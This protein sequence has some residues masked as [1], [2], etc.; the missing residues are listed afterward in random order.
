MDKRTKRNFTHPRLGV[1]NLVTVGVLVLIKLLKT[2]YRG[3]RGMARWIGIGKDA[4]A[5]VTARQEAA[6]SKLSESVDEPQARVVRRST[7]SSSISQDGEPPL[8]WSRK[9]AMKFADSHAEVEISGKRFRFS[10]YRAENEIQRMEM[11]SAR[12]DK[13][14]AR[15]PLAPFTRSTAASEKVA[16]TLEEA[17]EYTRREIAAVRRR[18]NSRKT[19]AP[20]E[21]PSSH[22]EPQQAMVQKHPSQPSVVEPTMDDGVP[23]WAEMPCFEELDVQAPHRAPA[24]EPVAAAVPRTRVRVKPP[25]PPATQHQHQSRLNGVEEGAPDFHGAR[26][27]TG[28]VVGFGIIEVKK[29][30]KDPFEIYSITLRTGTG[31]EEQ[32]RGYELEKHVK[33]NRVAVG[34]TIS[35]KRGRQHFWQIRNGV[36]KE[37]LRNIYDFQVVNRGRR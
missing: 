15:K 21:T 24:P 5:G 1:F 29:P 35:L 26:R 36:R 6:R 7:C 3:L 30:M 13:A 31:E 4:P 32:F 2:A 11:G 8:I 10:V 27:V 17:I 34:D 20:A 14:G 9:P 19:D 23:P 16:F 22:P 33:S 18:G 12:K 37:K 25:A 28:M